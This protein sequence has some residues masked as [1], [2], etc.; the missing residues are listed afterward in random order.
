[1]SLRESEKSEIVDSGY[2][3]LCYIVLIALKGGE[4][5]IGHWMGGVLIKMFCF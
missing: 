1:M 4:K 3:L 2:G 5:C